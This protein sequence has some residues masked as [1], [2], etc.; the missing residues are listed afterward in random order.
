MPK[1]FA[2]IRRIANQEASQYIAEVER[3]C[4]DNHVDLSDTFIDDGINYKSQQ[5]NI[6]KLKSYSRFKM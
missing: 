1:A 6:Y 3:Y 5:V 2:Y 4:N